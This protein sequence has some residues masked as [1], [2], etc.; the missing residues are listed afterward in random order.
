MKLGQ[1]DPHLA[2]FIYNGLTLTTDQ[3]IKFDDEKP[4]IYLL[5]ERQTT[6]LAIIRT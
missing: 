3:K 1:D 5:R 6:G 4:V 2:A